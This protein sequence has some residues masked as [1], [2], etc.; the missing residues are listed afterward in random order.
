MNKMSIVSFVKAFLLKRKKKA[1]LRRKILSEKISYTDTANNITKS[2]A[3]SNK[4]YKELITKVHPDLFEESNKIYA[5]ELSSKITKNKKNYNELLK[6]KVQVERF[7]Q[8]K[9]Q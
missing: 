7:L 9:K 4:L 1:E 8:T 3:H 5:T 6:L 2:I